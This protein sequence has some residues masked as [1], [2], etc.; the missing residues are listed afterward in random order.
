[1][2][3]KC[4]IFTWAMV[5]P[6]KWRIFSAVFCAFQFI[7]QNVS[8]DPNDVRELRQRFTGATDITIKWRIGTAAFP[9]LHS[10]HKMC[11]S[12][13]PLVVIQS[14]VTLVW[15]LVGNSLREM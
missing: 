14:K 6:I 12:T 3:N 7:S 2:H 8:K 9:V 5:I 11:V 13:R 4:Q 1:M 10:A 15:C